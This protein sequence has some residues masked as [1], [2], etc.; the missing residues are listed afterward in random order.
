[1][2]VVFE[3]LGCR[4]QR[5]SYDHVLREE[6]REHGH[7]KTSWN[8]LLETRNGPDWSNR[9]DFANIDTAIV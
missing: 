1:M 2:N 3:K 6:E 8:T 7:L 4:F 9:M 5:E